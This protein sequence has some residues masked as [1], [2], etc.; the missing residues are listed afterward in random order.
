MSWSDPELL[1]QIE[2]IE[3]AGPKS[4]SGEE[5][6]YEATI[7]SLNKMIATGEPQRVTMARV[8]LALAPVIRDMKAAVCARDAKTFA[9]MLAGFAD[10][11]GAVTA[12]IL[13]L[14]PECARPEII[15]R[16]ERAT[17]TATAIGEALSSAAR[18]DRT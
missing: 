12:G 13:S 14:T 15:E 16:I 11:I 8:S 17:I 3:A 9:H 7:A 18:S 4:G 5:A 2:E 10:A 1:K 6:L